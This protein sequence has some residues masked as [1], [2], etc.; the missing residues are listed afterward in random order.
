MIEKYESEYT[1]SL[2]AVDG[3]EKLTC[4]SRDA[5]EDLT[6]LLGLING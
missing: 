5:Y 1:V 3:Y 6:A 4:Y 2:G